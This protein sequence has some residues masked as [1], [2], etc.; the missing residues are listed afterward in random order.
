MKYHKLNQKEINIIYIQ[1]INELIIYIN[2]NRYDWMDNK[3]M[4]SWNN[5]V[6][7]FDDSEHYVL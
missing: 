2:I 4:I 1:I 5:N 7:L 3:I 6:V